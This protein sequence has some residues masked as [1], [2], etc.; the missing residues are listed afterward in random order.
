MAG[1]RRLKGI[2]R[3]RRL[4]RRMPDALRGELIVELRITGRRI[5]QA[6]AARAPKKTGALQAGIIDRVLPTSIRLQVGLLGSRGYSGN[7]LFY[8]RI[9]DLGRKAQTVMVQ[10]RRRVTV[11][12]SRGT[13][14]SVLRTH[15]GR[16]IAADV[17][18][19]YPM[20]VPAMAP[21]RFITGRYPELRSELRANLSGIFARSLSKVSGGGD[22]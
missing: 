8:G 14:L 10:R 5:R 6:I 11:T 22:E 17:S 20:R 13:I 1:R 4:L 19:T 7:R 9:Q 18:A 16:K 2:M 12:F 15:R 3:V 21:K